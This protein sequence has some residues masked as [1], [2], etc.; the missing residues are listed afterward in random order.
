MNRHL[1]VP[2]LYVVKRNV[3]ASILKVIVSSEN[4]L[5]K[6]LRMLLSILTIVT[7]LYSVFHLVHCHRSGTP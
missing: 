7:N 1:S 6:S 2:I 5:D 4:D 3:D